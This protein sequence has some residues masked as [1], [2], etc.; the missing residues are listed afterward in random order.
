MDR[1]A[2]VWTFF[3]LA[4]VIHI[5]HLNPAV[6]F[7]A[8]LTHDTYLGNKQA[9]KYNKV[10]TNYGNGYDK[11][12]G[13]FKAPMKGLYAF[14][15]SV[16]AIN[17]HA[18]HIELVKNGQVVSTIYSNPSSYDQA[19]ETVVLALKKGEK[20]WARQAYGGRHVRGSFNLFTGY[21][22]STQI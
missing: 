12:S 13:H 2:F 16:M 17:T 10:I 11:W 5:G 18:L 21:L 7:S 15:C 4:N 9:V 22:I 20:V 8:L 14:S 1:K 3:F 6:G 19:S